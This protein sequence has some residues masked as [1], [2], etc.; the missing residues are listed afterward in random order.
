MKR[1]LLFLLTTMLYFNGHSQISF[2][3]GYYIDNNNNRVNCII[4]NSDWKNNPTEFEYKLTENSGPET[5]TIKTVKEFG[6]D[7]SL[8]YIRST[9]KIDRSSKSLMNLSSDK[10]PFFQEEEL[11]LKGLVDS[12]AS[13]YQYEQGNLKRYFFNMEGSTIEQLIFK[14]YKTPEKKVAENNKFRQQ[15]WVALKC[16]NFKMGAIENLEYN[17]KD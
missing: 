13:L 6:I 2:E 1:Q 14:K 12:K 17:K 8:K 5:A 9:V 3:K 15:L 10:D 4:K 16:P 7:N 11:F